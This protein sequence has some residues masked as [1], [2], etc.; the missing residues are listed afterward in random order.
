VRPEEPA[1]TVVGLPEFS[2]AIGAHAGKGHGRYDALLLLS[3]GKDSAFVLH[4]MRSAFPALRLL[5]LT[6]DN[7]FLAPVALTN[8]AYTARALGT[9]LLIVRSRTREFAGT[10]RN[11]FLSLNGKG[12]YSV[13][14]FADGTLIYQVGREVAQE[15]GIPLVIGGLSW[16][17]LEHIF[18][19][20]GF[21]LPGAGPVRTFCPLAVWRVNEQTI[22]AAVRALSLL[23]PGQ[24][25]PL[26]TNSPLVAAMCVVDILTLGYCSFEPEFAQLVREGK[27]DRQLWLHLFEL[28][29]YLT[30]KGP[31]QAEANRVL[32]RLGLS[33]NQ[34]VGGAS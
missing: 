14:D 10:L 5:C 1:A 24:D 15:L 25:S 23:P 28:A 33:L 4:R 13:V 16:V 17:Q 11:A 34:V 9:D 26:A 32:G 31:L 19:T 6:V 20:S 12:A 7:G 29:E 18:G 30:W 3:G 27:T 21:E 8:A 2:E 22:R